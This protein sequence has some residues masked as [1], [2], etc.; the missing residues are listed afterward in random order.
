MK[1]DILFLGQY[2]YPGNNSSATLP[3]DTARYLS[4]CGYSV[5]VLTGYHSEYMAGE[6][7]PCKENL[8]GV[9][10][11]RIRYAQLSRKN[12]L[13]RLINYFSFTFNA[14]LRVGILRKY[15]SVIVYSNPPLIPLVAVL[16]N[17][18]FGTKIVFVAY[19]VYPE[20]AYAS[21]SL[22][23]GGLIDKTMKWINRQLYK[24]ASAVV[25]LTGEM[26]SFLLENRPE[27][28]EDRVHVIANWAHEQTSQADEAA[29]SAFGYGKD[30]FII[31]YFGNLGICQD[32]ETMLDAAELLK[33]DPQIRF[34]IVGHGTKFEYVAEQIRER[35]LS[36]V[37]LL[38][39][40]TGKKFQQAVAI[41][42]C[43]L[44]TLEKGVKGMC[45]PSKFY[46]YLQGG[47][48]VLAVVEEGSYLQEEIL[49]EQVGYAVNL[50]GASCLVKTI[51]QLAK[52][53]E[54]CKKMGTRACKL[55]DENYAM[56]I[57]VEKYRKM[58][59][60]LL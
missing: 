39:F 21:G 57:G 42:N 38:S 11:R 22:K 60:A 17:M 18:F 10:I 51:R 2:F 4:Q 7:I 23:P 5:G 53:P 12:K 29:F 52:N 8:D 31:S 32:V 27:L 6:K 26:K 13:G 43:C 20:V 30:N 24:R 59:D 33:A 46:S 36:N 54:C 14:L 16:G 3:T 56:Q 25:A 40:L 37:Q 34:L 9:Y 28:T 55:Y 49:R 35:A 44:V 19:D 1:K 47:K 45:A 48:P 50:G 58:F 15:K 41:S